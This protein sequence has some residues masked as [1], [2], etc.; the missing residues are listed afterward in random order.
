MSNS[1][2]LEKIFMILAIILGLGSTIDLLY[3]LVTLNFQLAEI[4]R[5]IF[6]IVIAV[7]LYIYASKKYKAK[8]E[9]D[10]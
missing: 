1:M 3:S 6:N 5:C 2:S 7:F 10:S 8:L 4:L 9:C